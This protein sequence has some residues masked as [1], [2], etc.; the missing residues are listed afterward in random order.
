MGTNISTAR[1]TETVPVF[2]SVD[3]SKQLHVSPSLG[4]CWLKDMVVGGGPS[5]FILVYCAAR[6]GRNRG[7]NFGVKV[8]SWEL[9]K[10]VEM[11]VL[12]TTR[13]AWKGGLQGGTFFSECTLRGDCF[14]CSGHV[15]YTKSGHG[16]VER[17][18]TRKRMKMTIVYSHKSIIFIEVPF[19]LVNV[20]KFSP[21]NRPIFVFSITIHPQSLLINQINWEPRKS[22]NFNVLLVGLIKLDK[23]R[24]QFSMKRGFLYPSICSD[25]GSKH[26]VF[27]KRTVSAWPHE[28]KSLGFRVF[29]LK[30]TWHRL[31]RKI[32]KAWGVSSDCERS[33]QTQ[34]LSEAFTGVQFYM[35]LIPYSRYLRTFSAQLWKRPFLR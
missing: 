7:A 9:K 16:E 30:G 4:P 14:P 25:Q 31:S 12:R 23:H 17:T 18:R 35:N 8:R 26:G 15:P 32:F 3:S 6:L 10:N 24:I 13:R 5:T 34:R 1:E 21:M 27:W 2:V 28:Q 19:V 11:G 29:T 20:V 22:K 33:E